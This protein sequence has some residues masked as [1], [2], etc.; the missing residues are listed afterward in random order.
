MHRHNQ[1]AF[2]QCIELASAEVAPD[3][4]RIQDEVG[5]YF[6]SS[7]PPS[8]IEEVSVKFRLRFVIDIFRM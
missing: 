1:P 6:V 4:D 7:Y 2:W 8:P 5:N 3:V